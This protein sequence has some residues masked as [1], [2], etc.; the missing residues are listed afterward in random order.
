MPKLKSRRG[1]AKRFKLTGKGR[2][3][4]HRTGAGHLMTRKSRKRKRRLRQADL[5]HKVDETKVRRQLGL[6]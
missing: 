1:A 4:R 3:R 2:I 6:E 5:V